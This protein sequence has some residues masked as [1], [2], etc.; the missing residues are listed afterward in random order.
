MADDDY[1][2]ELELLV[3]AT[4]A[5][6]GPEAYGME[7]R[8]DLE[9]RTGREVSIGAVYATL[10]RLRAKG[11]AESEKGEPT[12]ERG[13]RAKR[14]F[15]LRPAG[16]RALQRSRRVYLEALGDLPGPVQDGSTSP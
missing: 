13:G 9:R 3:A 16:V 15:R 11:Y 6:L 5:R 8:R 1:L 14:F 7:I 10:R 12:P 4:I 2:G